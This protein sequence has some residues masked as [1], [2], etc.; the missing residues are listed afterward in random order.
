MAGAFPAI[1]YLLKLFISRF[2][3]IKVISLCFAKSI[4]KH[5]E[6]FSCWLQINIFI[7]NATVPVDNKSV[8]N[9]RVYFVQM[10]FRCFIC[11]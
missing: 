8:F 6:S 3:Q 7:N 4:G 9:L 5:L 11:K 1:F 2:R 10:S